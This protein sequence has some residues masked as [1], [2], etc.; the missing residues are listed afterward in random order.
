MLFKNAAV[1]KHIL[2]NIWGWCNCFSGQIQHI[3]CQLSLK[4]VKEGPGWDMSRRP[5]WHANGGPG[6][7]MRE[8]LAAPE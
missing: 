5:D 2:S 7:G 1:N 4:E 8:D 6:Q 3:S